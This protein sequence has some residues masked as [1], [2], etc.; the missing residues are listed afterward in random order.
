MSARRPWVLGPAARPRLAFLLA[1]IS[2]AA[3]AGFAA[4]FVTAAWHGFFNC[5]SAG[6][7]GCA[8]HP[9]WGFSPALYLGACLVGVAAGGVIAALGSLA[10]LGWLGPRRAAYPIVAL[11]AIGVLSYGGLGIGAGAG[12]AAGWFLLRPRGSRAV[13]P[14]E[15]SGSLP[16]GV[17][18]VR[19]PPKRP[20]TDRPPVTEWS[21][22]LAG[23]PMT[24]A[25]RGGGKVPLP[26]ADRLAAALRRSRVAPGGASL[27]ASA[28]PPIVFLPPPPLALRR[29]R[30]SAGPA[31]IAAPTGSS[32]E[33]AVPLRPELPTGTAPPG[34]FPPARPA[35][36]S[37][38][39]APPGTAARAPATAA[40]PGSST[41]GSGDVEPV[42][43]VAP[44]PAAA[45]GPL[46]RAVPPPAIDPS[47]R[48]LRTSGGAPA[49]AAA[50]RAA[51]VP[52]RGP[53]GGAQL[54][55]A[56]DLPAVPSV[57]GAD[58]RP[59]PPGGPLSKARAKAWNCPNC[60]LLNAPWSQFCTACR[61][62]AP[63]TA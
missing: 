43:A 11:A 51:I 14:S 42:V 54:R 26:S 2:G 10:Y 29:G 45:A 23:A 53:A 25:S 7:A 55:P 4:V 61:T 19:G 27:A 50:P 35:G 46:R 48:S 32:P 6:A 58:S 44:G 31:A 56:G 9:F 38:F 17:P 62:P 40:S 49:S 33:A 63:P 18:A 28:S 13:A 12:V 39:S 16:T 5:P 37:S 34:T 47:R 15:W 1:V 30:P 22:V 57:V 36:A 60:K 8:S 3:T 24:P 20:L 59:P 21:G 52:P 41:A